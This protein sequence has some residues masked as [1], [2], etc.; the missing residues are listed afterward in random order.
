MYLTQNFKKIAVVAFASTLLSASNVVLADKHE[1]NQ[2]VESSVVNTDSS[3]YA[4]N[5][6]EALLL[7]NIKA[8]DAVK[9]KVNFVHLENVYTGQT[10]R[11][12]MRSGTHMLKIQAGVYKADLARLSHQLDANK[13]MVSKGSTQISLVPQSVSFAG[14]W[15]FSGQGQ[16]ASLTIDSSNN[17]AAAVA[18]KYPVVAQY[19]LRSVKKGQVQ[20]VALEWPANDDEMLSFS[21]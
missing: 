17:P 18:K 14:T 20:M 12:K 9:D 11:L 19:P 8:D 4:L 10:Y 1:N 7:M 6:S 21:N 13:A 16:D 15:E 5:R 3:R 2:T